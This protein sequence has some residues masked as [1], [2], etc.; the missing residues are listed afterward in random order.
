M[1]VIPGEAVQ[2]DVVFG[3][4][5]NSHY[6]VKVS[7]PE[8]YHVILWMRLKSH[9]ADG[10]TDLNDPPHLP[11]ETYGRIWFVSPMIGTSRGK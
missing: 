3:E 9:S 8:S 1:P 6:R 5:G 11:L 10:N 7:D 2:N 4:D